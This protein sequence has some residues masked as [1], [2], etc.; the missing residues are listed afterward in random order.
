ME[1]E[2]CKRWQNRKR[3]YDLIAMEDLKIPNMVKSA[4]GTVERPG[5]NVEAK[6]GL[7]RS[8]SEQT[9]GMLRRQLEYKAKWHGKT[10]EFV[11]A[12][13]TS[14]TCSACGKVSSDSRRGKTCSCADCGSTLDADVNAARVILQKAMA[15]GNSPSFSDR[16]IR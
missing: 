1:D 3:R 8:I 12:A 9:W 10:I 16:N 6:S 2:E 7:N 13:Y 15:G 14:Q 4:A 5:C 11:N